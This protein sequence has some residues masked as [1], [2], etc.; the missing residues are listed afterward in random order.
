MCSVCDYRTF[1]KVVIEGA[2][3]LEQPLG[4]GSLVMQCDTNGQNYTIGVKGEPIKGYYRIYRCPTCG[5]QLF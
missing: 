4:L 1:E 5:R 2:E 3:K